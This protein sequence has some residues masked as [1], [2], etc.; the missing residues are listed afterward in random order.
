PRPG[1]LG[2]R[3]HRR[4]RAA[5][6]A[7]R[8]GVPRTDPRTPP[9]RAGGS[10]AGESQ[11]RR[12]RHHGRRCR[13][14]P[15]LRASGGAARPV[16]D[17]AS[18]SVP[19]LGVDPAGRWRARNVRLLRGAERPAR[20][21]SSPLELAGA[22]RK[23]E[24]V[25]G[26][27]GRQLRNRGR[28]AQVLGAVRRHAAMHNPLVRAVV[29]AAA[30]AAEASAG[31]AT[32]DKPARVVAATV[33][34]ARIYADEL[35]PSA[36]DESDGTVHD[37]R[38]RANIRAR[39]LE[40]RIAGPLARRFCGEQ[41]CSLTRAELRALRTTFGK[42]LCE[43]ADESGGS[44]ESDEKT[45]DAVQGRCGHMEGMLRDWAAGWK[46][47]KALHKKYGGRVIMQTLGPNAVEA[48]RR[49]LEDEE[50]SGHFQIADSELRADFYEAVSGYGGRTISAE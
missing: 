1:G 34:S 27:S 8:A 40:S 45:R 23:V 16:H 18:A 11:L 12:W 36:D 3:L 31:E 29:L 22:R 38:W 48:R 43:V 25:V 49:W 2:R 44:P 6:R 5:D 47:H 33:L 19:V 9:H 41:G 13:S 35:G 28:A 30:V 42:G 50:A 17:A 14:L 7:L 37:E 15:V 32:A 24:P 46:L 39:R 21:E 10:R 20:L 26:G 4:D